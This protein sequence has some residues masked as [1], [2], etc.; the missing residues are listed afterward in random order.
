MTEN[1]ERFL[2]LR[3]IKFFKA[4]IQLLS[5]A[6][7]RSYGATALS[8]GIVTLL[9]YLTGLSADPSLATVVIGGVFVLLS[10]PFLPSE[11][12]IPLVLQ[13]F[14]VTDY[15]FFDFFCIKR[16][17]KMETAKR[18]P[19]V[20]SILAGAILALVGLV[21]PIR[22]VSFLLGAVIFV[23]ITLLSPEFAFFTTF[24]VLPYMSLVPSST[25]IFASII[26]LTV[27]SF[28]RKAYFGKR[29][30]CIDG[31]DAIIGVLMV[32]V[33]VSGIFVKG[34][35]SFT[36]SVG[37]VLMGFGYI[38]SGNVVTNRRLADRALNSIVISS[39]PPAVIGIVAFV[40]ELASGR[41]AQ[42]IDKGVSST[43]PNSEAA[44]AF[45]VVALFF[46]FA[47]LIQSH[48]AKKIF[49]AAVF[50]V[51]FA[52]LA[53]TGEL[54]AVLALL[55]GLIAYGFI[56]AFRGA[57]VFLPVISVLPYAILILPNRLL[58]KIFS[59]IPSLESAGELFGTWGASLSAFVRNIMFG[60]GLGENCFAEEMADAGI[61]A[62]N[63][64]NIFIE[65]GLEAGFF[66]LACFVALLVV[67]IFHK[68]GYNS[69]VRNSEVSVLSPICSVC[70]YS[71]V[72]YGAFNYVF[73]DMFSM[74][75][76]W[77][78]FGIGSAALR[79]AKRE[80]DDR[81]HY[82]EDTR[83]SNSSA[84]DIEIL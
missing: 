35:S 59:V 7:S 19:I 1:K 46:S 29:F 83:A 45:T 25:V 18:V 69:Y 32:L 77:C 63:S 67:R 48:G 47:Q 84:I 71:L 56:R 27:L 68:A 24:L 12:P 9:L 80:T 36:W 55:L 30:A 49:Y 72:A 37:M 58:D 3:I 13:D 62:K 73:A 16:F 57:V 39:V 52:F 8:F 26:L 42:L 33:L 22:L 76:F 65:L 34:M 64:S 10:L 40:R 74:Y 6:P 17:N 28:A 60:I 14:A 51:Q 20:I 44:A 66:A 53:L 70:V 2:S 23:G 15:V 79:V 82:Y 78:V 21:Y 38:I 81:I 75:L 50:A 5:H 41:G 61:T 54:F 31:Y 43:F 4:A 11:R